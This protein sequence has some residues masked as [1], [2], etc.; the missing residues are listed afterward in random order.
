MQMKVLGLDPSH[1]GRLPT[2]AFLWDSAAP[3]A[4][5]LAELHS[6]CA[7][8]PRALGCAQQPQKAARAETCCHAQEWW[9]GKGT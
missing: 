2:P 1:L 3:G 6:C 4:V 5:L 9:A 8:R 7:W